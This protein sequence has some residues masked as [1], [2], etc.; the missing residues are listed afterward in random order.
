[1]CSRSRT[2]ERSSTVWASLQQWSDEADYS[3]AHGDEGCRPPRS[4]CDASAPDGTARSAH[5]RH[6]PAHSR[7]GHRL[8]SCDRFRQA[9]SAASFVP[10][11]A[12]PERLL[13]AN[14]PDH[15]S[16]SPAKTDARPPAPALRRARASMTPAFGNWR[17]CRAPTHTAQ[18]RRPSAHPSSASPCHRSPARHHC[19]R[20]A[21]SAWTRS[22]ASRGAAS[23]TP[24]AT[25]WCNRS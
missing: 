5:S 9:R 14:V 3:V 25:K 20:R 24:A 10:C 13:A 22:S 7:S 19:R 17:S 1:M 11:D 23:H 6:R 4:D 8:R 2:A 21:C 16:S 15:C 12:R 18:Q